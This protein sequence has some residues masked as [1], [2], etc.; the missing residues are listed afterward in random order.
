MKIEWVIIV[1]RSIVG[2]IGSHCWRLG[3]NCKA[4]LYEGVRA[5]LCTPR[6]QIRKLFFSHRLTMGRWWEE[7]KSRRGLWSFCACN[8]YSSIYFAAERAGCVPLDSLYWRSDF[9]RYSNL[10][11]ALSSFE[12]LVLCKRWL[13][14]PLQFSAMEKIGLFTRTFGFWMCTRVVGIY[15]EGLFN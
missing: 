2:K 1:R 12:M 7:R 8:K 13:K 9:L 3:Q 5:A 6:N 4:V 10:F 14:E 15:G 11:T